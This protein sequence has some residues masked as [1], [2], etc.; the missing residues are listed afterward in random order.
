MGLPAEAT[1]PEASVRADLAAL[2][3]ARKRDIE[4][5]WLS[6][7]TADGGVS[8]I[9]LADLR[10]AMPDYLTLSGRRPWKHPS[11]RVSWP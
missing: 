5:E 1:Q 6:R 9:D 4:Q 2:L 10:D 8:G 7:V 11:S 3:L